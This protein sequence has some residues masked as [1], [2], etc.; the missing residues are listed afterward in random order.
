M[1]GRKGV[2]RSSPVI[3]RGVRWEHVMYGGDTAGLFITLLNMLNGGREL[4]GMLLIQGASILGL[5]LAG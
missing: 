3:L 1:I 5:L 2:A 4:A